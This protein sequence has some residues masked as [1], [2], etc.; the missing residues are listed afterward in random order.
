MHVNAAHKTAAG[1][2]LTAAGTIQTY[3][4]DGA[5]D[6]NRQLKNEMPNPTPGRDLSVNPIGTPIYIATRFGDALTL[7]S[8]SMVET[9]TN[10]PV[11]LRIP[12]SEVND[13]NLIYHGHEGYVAPDAPLKAGSQYTVTVTGSANGAAFSK[14][15]SFKT[16]A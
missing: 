10:T 12:V 6:V 2:Q 1:K 9:L 7:A 14:T 8:A 15:F 5:T 4:C 3:P 16:G 11:V 13:P